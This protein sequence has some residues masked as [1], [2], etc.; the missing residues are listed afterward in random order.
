MLPPGVSRHL[1]F[2]EE[3]L[4][5]GRILICGQDST[6]SPALIVIHGGKASSQAAVEYCKS[7]YEKL[8]DLGFPAFSIDY[9]EK[10]TLIE[11]VNYTVEAIKHVKMRIHKS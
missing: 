3:A 4:G 1:R 11:E 9:P 7:F 6:I 2:H 5:N 10:M 8:A